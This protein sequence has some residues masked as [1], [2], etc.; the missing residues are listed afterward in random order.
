MVLLELQHKV[1]SINSK[2]LLNNFITK[3]VMV[4]KNDISNE[5]D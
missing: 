5:L 4:K 3:G 1:I 2:H